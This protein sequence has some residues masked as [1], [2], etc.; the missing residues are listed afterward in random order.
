MLVYD[1]GL[2]LPIQ[3]SATSAFNEFSDFQ[4]GNLPFD[5]S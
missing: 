4:N 1:D 5:I 3:P 2:H